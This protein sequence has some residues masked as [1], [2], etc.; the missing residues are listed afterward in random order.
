[1]AVELT[2]PKPTPPT[3]STATNP[4][5]ALGLG[6]K[7]LG[8]RALFASRKEVLTL[9]STKWLRTGSNPSPVDYRGARVSMSYS[10][11]RFFVG[12][13]PGRA[14]TNSWDSREAMV[15]ANDSNIAV[16]SWDGFSTKE[17]I[18][19]SQSDVSK[20]RGIFENKNN[21][22]I[23][24]VLT[25]SSH[26]GTLRSYSKF[27]GS[28]LSGSYY[29]SLEVT[30]IIDACCSPTEV[31]IMGNSAFT[32]NDEVNNR[33]FVYGHDGVFKRVIDP[34]FRGQGTASLLGLRMAWKEG[35]IYVI[36]QENRPGVT[37]RTIRICDENGNQN[38]VFP[39]GFDTG[40][41]E[42]SIFESLGSI[43]HGQSNPGYRAIKENFTL[44]EYKI[45]GNGLDAAIFYT[46]IL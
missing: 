16:V 23:L 42:N 43:Y 8:S 12:S 41:F 27:N 40:V 4:S 6:N 3:S 29:V 11:N 28:F 13:L 17:Y 44:T 46:R 37:G 26:Y 36:R 25:E 21:T 19:H 38:T 5:P 20:I 34:W 31:F 32:S 15:A 7:P 18:P 14:R 2:I 24:Y 39:N 30:D 1:M 10:G 45:G 22:D 33:I 9:G 35:F